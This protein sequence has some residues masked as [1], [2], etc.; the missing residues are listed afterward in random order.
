MKKVNKEVNTKNINFDKLD[1]KQKVNCIKNLLFNTDLNTAIS[2]IVEKE[3]KDLK[4]ISIIKDC[5]REDLIKNKV[6]EQ[7]YIKEEKDIKLYIYSRIISY[8]SFYNKK[9]ILKIFLESL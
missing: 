9:V 3:K 4:L 1:D 7:A 8:L 5:I 6:K 2:S